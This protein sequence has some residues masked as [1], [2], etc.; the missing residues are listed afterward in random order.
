MSGHASA[1]T[2]PNPVAIGPEGGW[3]TALA[4]SP[5]FDVD[6]RAWTATFGGHIFSGTGAAGAWTQ[7]HAG[8]TDPVVEA[9]A[10]SPNFAADSTVF[11]A[12][13]EGVFRSTDGGATWGLTSAGLGHHFCRALV[14]SPSYAADHT[15]YVATDGGVY[16]STDGGLSWV[17][18]LDSPRSAISLAEVS[19]GGGAGTLFAGLD[20]GGLE[21]STDGG[22][23]WQSV[24]NFPSDRRALAIALLS[25]AATYSAVVG[26]DNGIWR[27]GDGESVWRQVGALSDRIDTLA[28]GRSTAAAT[29]LY[30]GSAGGHGVYVSVDSGISWR[31]A[32]APA[33]PFVTTLAS[34]GASTLT[35]RYHRRRHFGID[36]WRP[37]LEELQPWLTG[38]P[39]RS[40]HCGRDERC[41]CRK[42]WRV[43]AGRRDLTMASSGAFEPL[44]DLRSRPG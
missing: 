12:A 2:A 18:P 4:V 43:R 42:R 26:T 29:S 14:I 33:V 20:A 8:E 37:E 11:A 36:R 7:S 22:R 30:A 35:C 10:V 39:G 5:A 13:D 27:L 34:A 24:L 6:G 1:L 38:I 44:C 21:Q 32:G 16:R 31:Q 3:I 41:R 23:H 17:P 9:L 15:V 28:V 25:G 40:A 19:T